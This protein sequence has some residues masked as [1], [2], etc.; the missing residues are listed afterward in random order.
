MPRTIP[1]M[2]EWLRMHD[3]PNVYKLSD[4]E[5]RALYDI[6]M[7]KQEGLYECLNMMQ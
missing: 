5:V 6:L 2:R 3:H 1:E 7:I 4:T